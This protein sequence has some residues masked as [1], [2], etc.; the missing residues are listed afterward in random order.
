VAF[1]AVREFLEILGE[2]AVVSRIDGSKRFR[3]YEAVGNTHDI[4][5]L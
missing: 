1:G 2:L 4:K 3:S 5:R